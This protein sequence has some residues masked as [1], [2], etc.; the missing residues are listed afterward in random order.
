V[1]YPNLPLK[2]GSHGP[3]V[4]EVQRALRAR[5]RWVD[6]DGNY[7]PATAKAV[8]GYQK[9]FHLGADGVVGPNT[10]QFMFPILREGSPWPGAVQ[11]L[12]TSLRQKEYKAADKDGTF[13]PHT[14]AAV[15][16][17]QHHHKLTADGV[18][19]AKTWYVLL[20]G[21]LPMGG[22]GGTGTHPSEDITVAIG[23]WEGC[24]LPYAKQD[25]TG[26]WTIGYGYTIGVGPHT[27]PWTQQ[28]ALDVLQTSLDHIFAPPVRA[29]GVQLNQKQF[30]ALI[31][32]T[33]NL[34]SGPI[35]AGTTVGNDLRAHNYV[36]AANAFL[37]YD[38]AAGRVLPGLL[39][40]RQW[41]RQL[42]LGGSYGGI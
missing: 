38:H 9:E 4:Y 8:S 26:R 22:S 2:L 41:E 14:K 40:R 35:A 5:E 19:G 23:K 11:A 20:G 13:G 34:G 21:K 6:A 7:V 31:S 28:H 36:G 32:F 10:W 37:A 27:G 1:S 18:V 30:D 12:Q 24:T 25:I 16:D 42:F 3:E 33:Y 15:T 17:F 39:R 29:I